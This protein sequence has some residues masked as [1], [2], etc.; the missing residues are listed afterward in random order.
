MRGDQPVQELRP[1]GLGERR[2]VDDRE[3]QLG[4]GRDDEMGLAADP[5][6]ARPQRLVAAHDLRQAAP[7]G[8]QIER[9]GEPEGDRDAIL[10]DP[11]ELQRPFLSERRGQ[12][13]VTRH[14][15]RGG[16]AIHTHTS[17]QR[18]LFIWASF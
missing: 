10:R 5:A 18:G 12:R 13:L 2:K 1:P 4:R 3:R 9:P 8:G 15:N 6:E 16:D 14:R 17:G 7:E 11:G